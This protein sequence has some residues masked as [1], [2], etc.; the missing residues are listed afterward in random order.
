MFCGVTGVDVSIFVS[1]TT[2]K[3]PLILA[4]AFSPILQE[5]SAP[6]LAV[7]IDSVIC[8]NTSAEVASLGV[9]F[10]KSKSVF[11]CYLSLHNR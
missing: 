6:G 8:F 2:N 10:S 5:L 7:H 4:S 3:T 1:F 9:L 11:E